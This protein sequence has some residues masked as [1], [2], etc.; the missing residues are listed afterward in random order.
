MPH[1][2]VQI[3]ADFVTT[4]KDKEPVA[5]RVRRM[6]RDATFD[7]KDFEWSL[8]HIKPAQA[9]LLA[10]IKNGG[11]PW[12]IRKP[13]NTCSGS[14]QPPSPTPSSSKP[15]KRQSALSATA[16]IWA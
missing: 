13:S 12:T 3:T 14:T 6:L 10:N 1:Y 8:Q 5:N 2:R 4:A 9:E 11:D 15:S 7:E 16:S